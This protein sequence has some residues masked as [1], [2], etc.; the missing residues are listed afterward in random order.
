M[1]TVAKD[2]IAAMAI[3]VSC[4]PVVAL[5]AMAPIEANA[6]TK[7]V[8]PAQ[9]Q[10]AVVAAMRSQAGVVTTVTEHQGA[11]FEEMVTQSG[12]SDGTQS[13]TV[14]AA[15]QTGTVN[16]VLTGGVV[17][18]RGNQ[19]GLGSYMGFTAKAAKELA[20]QWLRVGSAGG[21]PQAERSLFQA[22]SADLTVSTLILDTALPGPLSFATPSVVDGQHVN[23][24][25]TTIRQAGEPT[26]DVVLY[27]RASGAPLPV[28][29]IQTIK[30]GSGTATFRDWGK[31]P[32][33]N[34]PATA[35]A[36]RSSWLPANY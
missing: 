25:A 12:I 36:F 7:P 2:K 11:K 34:A 21:E 32:L 24:I 13:I 15:G 22:A 35:L 14:G 29:E 19:F 16:I 1:M 8:T 27:V 17:F 9:L 31:A 20:G 33:V 23:G 28:E 18:L 30:G 3:A 6:A 26:I 10:S 5:L 4:A